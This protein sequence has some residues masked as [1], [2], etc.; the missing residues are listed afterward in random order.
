MTLFGKLPPKDDARTLLMG[1]YL[2]DDIAPPPPSCNLLPTVFQNLNMNNVATLFPMDGNN[3]YGDCTIAAVAHA[4]TVYGGLVG[5]R[6]IMSELDVQNLYLHLTGGADNGLVEL[7][8]LNYWRQ[9]AISGDTILAYVKIDVRNHDHVKQ[10]IQ[11]LGGVY[12]GFQVQQNCVFQFQNRQPWVPGPLTGEG[13]AVYAVEYGPSGVTVLTWGSV[14][15]ATW[16]W[17]DACVDEAYAILPPE[18]ELAGIDMDQLRAD[19]AAVSS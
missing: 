11:L 12:V 1:N 4:I 9:N 3:R 8:V 16:D 10:A 14:Q 19:L 2:L 18:A 7:D 5:I 13:H 15:E 6:N 17:W